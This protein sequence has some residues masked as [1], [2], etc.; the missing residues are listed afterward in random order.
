MVRFQAFG[1]YAMA[2]AKYKQTHTPLCTQMWTHTHTQEHT[3]ARKHNHTQTGDGN[4]LISYLSAAHVPQTAPGKPL[5]ERDVTA[6]ALTSGE[7]IYL[8]HA[9]FLLPP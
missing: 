9:T 7:L 6:T 2:G 3:I 1:F 5:P 4:W 8:S